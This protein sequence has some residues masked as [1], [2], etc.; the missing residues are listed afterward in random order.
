MSEDSPGYFQQTRTLTYSFWAT[1]PL[2]VAYE[3]LII[4]ANARSNVMIEVG[5]AVWVKRVLLQ[6]GA[7]GHLGLGVA[8][9][10]LGL[11]VCHYERGEAVS[12]QPA[13]FAGMLVECVI[14]AIVLPLLILKATTFLL[15]HLQ[16]FLAPLG[17]TA[18]PSHGFIL[19]TALS[20]GAGL[21][22]ELV[23]RVLLFGALAWI[24]KTMLG[25]GKAVLGTMAAAVVGALLFSG[26]HYL[27][28]LGDHW[29]LQSFAYRFLFGLALTALYVARGFG[30]AAWTHA[31]YDLMV[32][33]L[34]QQ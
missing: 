17:P 19:R 27:G 23:F 8:A 29:S 33:H 2:L 32:V 16:S 11:V 26:V 18:A 25:G 4:W 10:G 3:V 24:L 30:I 1:V 20:L 6:L 22:E 5:A 13:Y 7:G 14:Y 9:L 21:Y 15:P 34:W 12:L 31:V 28:A